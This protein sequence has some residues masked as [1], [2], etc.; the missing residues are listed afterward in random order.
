MAK[1]ETR[2]IVGGN[3]YFFILCALI[4]IH[5]K[6]LVTYKQYYFK[7]IQ[8]EEY[9]YGVTMVKTGFLSYNKA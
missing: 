9:F 4:Y 5:N 7:H 8:Y 6:L 2:L 1:T 3:R